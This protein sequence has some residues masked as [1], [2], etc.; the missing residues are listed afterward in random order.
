MADK[1]LEELKQRKIIN[2]REKRKTKNKRDIQ[3]VF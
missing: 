3:V 1:W 2:E